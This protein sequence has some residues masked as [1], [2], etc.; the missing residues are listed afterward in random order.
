MAN[1]NAWKFH[2]GTRFRG[3]VNGV[4]MEIVRIEKEVANENL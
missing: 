2:P 3:N 4:E 1:E